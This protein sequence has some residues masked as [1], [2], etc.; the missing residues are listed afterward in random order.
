MKYFFVLL[1]IFSLL[2]FSGCKKEVITCTITYP[3]NNAVFPINQSI[4]VTVEAST[5]KG[6]IIQVQLTFDNSAIQ[7]L[8]EPPYNFTIPADSVSTLGIHTICV[9]AYNSEKMR[10]AAF[11]SISIE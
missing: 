11:I 2:L 1:S 6:S 9:E 5:T 4:P 3:E 10:E 8:T 7:S